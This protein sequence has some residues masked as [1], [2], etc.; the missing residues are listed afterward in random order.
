MKRK[1]LVLFYDYLINEHF[2][3]DVFLMPY[4]LGKQLGCDVS[5]VYLQSEVKLPES[6]RGVNLIPIGGNSGKKRKIFL[7]YKYVMIHAR[8]IDYMMRFH[9][10]FHTQ[11]LVILYKILNPHGKAYVKS[12]VDPVAI[13]QKHKMGMVSKWLAVAFNKKVDLVSCETTMAYQRMR[14]SDSPFYNYGDKLM[15][16]P[17]GFDEELINQLGIHVKS[18]DEKENVMLTI[19]RLGTYQKNTSM[20]LR[21]LEKVNMKDWKCYLIGTVESS[22]LI[23]I[24]HFYANNPDKREQVIFTGPI[25]DKRE[26]WEFYNRAKLFLLTSNFEGSPLVLSEAKRFYN[27][28]LTTEVGAASDITGQNEYG[29]LLNLNDDETLSVWIQNIVDGKYNIDVYQHFNAGTLSW[30]GCVRRLIA[31]KQFD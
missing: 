16:V 29:Y 23:E 12:D 1:K 19:G 10:K 15:M 26:L 8:S 2:G 20:L 27:Y 18:F 28:I 25:P 31:S 3:K 14:Q 30:E 21:A 7:Y 22:F 9:V 5:I 4:Y 11:L 13:P 24:E 17:N 6:V